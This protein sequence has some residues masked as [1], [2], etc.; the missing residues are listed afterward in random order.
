MNGKMIAK[1]TIK[2]VKEMA[3]T[4]KSGLEDIFLSLT[5]S[6]DLSNVLEYIK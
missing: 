3:K 1:G 2:E 5:G 6:P 4:E